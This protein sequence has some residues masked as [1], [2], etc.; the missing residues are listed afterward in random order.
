MSSFLLHPAVFFPLLLV[1]AAAAA[2]VLFL[3]QN[4]HSREARRQEEALGRERKAMSDMEKL[5]ALNTDGFKAKTEAMEAQLRGFESE[6]AKASA[7]LETLKIEDKRLKDQVEKMFRE[8]KDKDDVFKREM[9]MKE[10]LAQRLA[11]RDA[12]C[13]ALRKE[14]ELS[15]QAHEGLK[16]QYGE[17]EEKFSE[18]F[19]QFLTEQKKNKE[20]V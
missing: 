8:A 1:L 3:A 19:E 5:L 17:L 14:L 13:A 20:P 12:E 2:A 6:L 18:L 9:A 10:G 15:G 11:E 4:Q 16:G 7:E